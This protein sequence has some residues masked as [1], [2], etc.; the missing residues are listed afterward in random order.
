M[1][2]NEL[3][4]LIKDTIKEQQEGDLSKHPNKSVASYFRVMLRQPP[5]RHQ[6]LADLYD[7]MISAP[8][9]ALDR[10]AELGFSRGLV[11]FHKRGLIGISPEDLPAGQE[12][13]AAAQAAAEA[14]K[15]AEEKARAERAANPPPPRSMADIVYPR[16]SRGKIIGRAD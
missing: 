12:L 9:S 5:S 4:N 13:F 10:A 7:I 2:L 14:R 8:D 3:R 16:D 11:N 6:D 1:K 15:D